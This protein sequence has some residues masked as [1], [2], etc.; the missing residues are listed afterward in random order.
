[1]GGELAKRKAARRDMEKRVSK[2]CNRR[3]TRKMM[4][5]SAKGGQIPCLQSLLRVLLRLV[6]VHVVVP[7]EEL[8][9]FV[10]Q[11]DRF[12]CAIFCC[13]YSY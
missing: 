8:L 4:M 12:L 3:R 1:V 6:Y 5:A 13:D 10:R 11:F 9:L 2:D 7:R